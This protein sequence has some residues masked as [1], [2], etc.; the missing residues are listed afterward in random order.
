MT[1]GAPAMLL[2][3]SLIMGLARLL[4]AAGLPELWWSAAA[5]VPRDTGWCSGGVV[6]SGTEAWRLDLGAGASSLAQ[7]GLAKVRQ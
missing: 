4:T 2:Q 3:L 7:L 1:A 5:G 6:P